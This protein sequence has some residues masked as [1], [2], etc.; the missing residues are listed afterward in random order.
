MWGTFARFRSLALMTS[1]GAGILLASGCG[2]DVSSAEY[3][4]LLDQ[5]NT[6]AYASAYQWLHPVQKEWI[7]PERFAT[8]YAG[9]SAGSPESRVVDV[10]SIEVDRETKI[11][12]RDAITQSVAITATVE[13]RIGDEATRATRT[14]HLF[15]T[16]PLQSLGSPPR[17][18]MDAETFDG[19]RDGKC[20]GKT[21]AESIG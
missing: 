16:G 6:G 12:G 10:E 7:L 3:R 14:I 17:W 18:V 2:D 4:T 9:L 11:P 8:C 13:T 15:S 19:A 20:E 21:P 1:A 5:L